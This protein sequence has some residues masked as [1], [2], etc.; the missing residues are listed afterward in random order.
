M[1]KLISQKSNKY[2][3]EKFL[4]FFLVY[5]P[6]API[7]T[8]IF[9]LSLFGFSFWDTEFPF[10]VFS[11]LFIANNIKKK[12]KDIFLV[13]LFIAVLLIICGVRANIFGENFSKLLFKSWYLFFPFFIFSSFSTIKFKYYKT[14]KLVIISQIVFH[15]TIGFLHY[16]GLPT[17]EITGTSHVEMGRYEGIYGA[18]NVYSNYLFT[19][20][21]IYIL[22]LRKI[23]LMWAFT[24]L[25]VFGGIVVSGS[26]GPLILFI[27]VNVFFIL[28]AFKVKKRLLSFSIL[29]LVILSS[30]GSMKSLL[31]NNNFKESRIT[32]KGFDI[33]V[34][35]DKNALAV[36][37]LLSSFNSFMFGLKKNQI[38]SKSGIEVSDNSLT[39][40]ATA[41]GVIILFF[42][43]FFIKRL[44]K[45][46]YSYIFNIRGAFL[47][48]PLLFIFVAN[49]SVLWLPWVYISIFGIYL[50]KS[51]FLKEEID[52]QNSN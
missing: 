33:N 17:Y 15:G 35:S 43:L 29:T 22:L 45:I 8:S 1:Q 4:I 9:K 40:I 19:F 21:L 31:T 25:L 7:L 5:F 14:I 13:I 49:N 2:M 20:Y 38:I 30:L 24:S 6:L 32:Q 51:E 48:F 12:Q 10:G 18:S 23:Q 50:L 39:L 28:G 46:K 37:G 36:D 16:L 34:R 44:S 27:I 42:W 47:V 11:V 3:K 26:R 52:S 41:Y